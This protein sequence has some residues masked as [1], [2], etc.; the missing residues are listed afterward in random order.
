MSE[1]VAPSRNDQ[2]S[3]DPVEHRI[4]LPTGD[5]L[6]LQVHPG[7][8]GSPVV[9]I[10]PALGM[11]ARKYRGFLAD[12]VATGLTAVA[13]DYRGYG[14][15][16]PRNGPGATVSYADIAGTDFPTVVAELESLFPGRPLILLGHSIGGQT[17]IM[18][19]ASAPEKLAGAVFIGVSTPWIRAYP[20]LLKLVPALGTNLAAL[21]AS[22]VGYF[23]G[24]RLR[25]LGRQSKPLMHDWARLARTGNFD[26]IG[27]GVGYT[28][29]IERFD[30]D[31]L[32][33]D[34]EGDWM[35]PPAAVDDFCRRL[36]KARI[37]RWHA[38]PEATGGRVVG[39]INWIDDG[40]VIAER[41]A[42]WVARITDWERN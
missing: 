27:R 18:Y 4:A 21:L 22:I 39:H 25:F 15:S 34:V 2:G 13:V 40:A 11:A 10:W 14:A 26:K 12:L 42:D 23:P 36:G 41:I 35:A 5:E 30:S 9:M 17:G 1:D 31:V 38:G 24:D 20:G 32:V 3:S 29:L 37:D 7:P 19:A 6:A 33:V 8:P 16:T 28:E